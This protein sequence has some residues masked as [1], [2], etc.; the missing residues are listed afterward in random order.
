MS[1]EPS[2]T[3]RAGTTALASA[4]LQAA[5]PNISLAKELHEKGHFDAAAMQYEAVLAGQPEHAE[6]LHLYG[7]VQ[8]QRGRA[9]ESETLLRRAVSLTPEPMAHADLGAVMLAAGRVDDALEQFEAALRIDPRH[10]HA[11]VR[12]GNTLIGMRKYEQALASY[13]RAL[14]A[15]PLELDALCNRG[16][17]LRALGRHQ[18]ALETYDR[19]LTVDPLSAESFYNRGHVL[20]DLQRY[21]EALQSYDRAIALMP[22]HAAMLSMRGRTLIDLGR[23]N[24]ALASLNE[25]IAIQPHFVEALHNSAVALERVGRPAEAIQ[26]CERVLALEPWNSR[27]FVG[28]GNAW[29]RLQY[30]EE[31]LSSY[32]RALE[33]DPGSV[34]VL[35]NQAT[36]LRHLGRYEEALRD[37]DAALALDPRF[38]QAW[39]NRGNV[40]QDMHRYEEAMN[41]LNRAIA[42]RSDQ[43]VHWFNRGNVLYEMGRP[44]AALQAYD[45]AIALEPEHRDARIARASMYL[46]RGDFAQGW[47][48]Y[49]QCLRDPRAEQARR[50][51]A[52]PQWRGEY[53]LDGKT[54]LIHAEQGFG[55]TLQF[56]RYM[57]LLAERGANIVL[58]VQPAL[59]SLLA[60]SAGPVQVFAVGESLPP[61]DFHCPLPGLP[62]AFQTD[63]QSIPVGT[64]YVFPNANLVKKWEDLLG[65]KHRLRIGLAWSGNP[66]HPNDRHRSMELATFLPLLEPDV[67]WVNLQTI[68]RD[69]DQA[70]LESSLIRRFD[71]EIADFSDTAA[72]MQSLDLVIT[73]DSAV[74]HLAGA[75]DRPVWI[76]LSDPPEWRWMRNRDDSPWYPSARLFRQPAPGNWDGVIEAV[77]GAIRKLSQRVI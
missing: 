9:D 61:A 39:G 44:D 11:L 5:A 56:C 22:G 65:P 29:L 19:A 3:G 50:V 21:A 17:A 76:L 77:R 31:A 62:F 48:E 20:R 10:I 64:P 26:R 2:L 43:A 73:V 13:D 37:Y 35:C 60:T 6:A 47:A 38:A 74:A 69:R 68:I 30:Y 28:R 52:Q 25:A 55:D 49:E 15:S 42:L 27:A 7:V 57:T 71:A 4:G 67:D 33:I 18:E 66:E 63:L 59:K 40:L 46:V 24:E 12:Q 51:F 41:S 23:P 34:D 58:E 45:K 36:A 53:A 72:L 8:Y 70:V 14:L 16:S 32:A 54:I 1:T 75:L